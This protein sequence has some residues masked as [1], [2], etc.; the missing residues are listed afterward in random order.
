[1]LGAPRTPRPASCGCLHLPRWSPTLHEFASRDTEALGCVFRVP[2]L[3]YATP[4]V[5]TAWPLVPRPYA[6]L[7]PAVA[8]SS[9]FHD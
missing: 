4:A 6:W 3:G 2:V 9:D 8:C 1:M 5:P 7:E